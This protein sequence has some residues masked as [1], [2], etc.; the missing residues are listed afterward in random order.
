MRVVEAAAF[1]AGPFAAMMLA[2]MGADLVKVEPPSGD[3]LRTFGRRVEGLGLN[4]VNTNRNKSSLT[5]DLRTEGGRAAFLDLLEHADMLITNWR[6]GV[7]EDFGL[8]AEIV[9]RQFP[10]LV[11]V[12]IT[13]Y[14]IDGPLASAPVFDALIQARSG[15]MVAQGE[16]EPRPVWSWIVDKVTATLAAQSGLAALAR[17]HMTGDGSIVDISMLDSFAYFNFPDLMTERTILSERDRPA[18]NTQNRGV[19]PVP[20]KDGWLM[21]N[22]VRGVQLKRALEAFGRA[23]SIAELKKL[24]NSAATHRFFVIAEEAAVARTTAEWLEI[25]AAH[26]VPAAPVFD[27]DAHYMDPQVVHNGTYTEIADPRFG[28]IRQ[29]RF[30]ARFDTGDA[31][32]V[33]APDLVRPRSED[34]EG[35]QPG[36]T[37]IGKPKR[38]KEWP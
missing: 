18:L 6:P 28:A 8:T 34:D 37:V 1:V 11:W 13:G 19:R 32:I 29:P 3:P 9:R 4:F 20:T 33:P 23:E 5:C 24:D 7:A 25:M 22:P 15:M 10:K 2:D 36:S 14:G 38:A 16:V 21:V 17:R 26:D 35:F 30:P 12:R 31:G 27:F